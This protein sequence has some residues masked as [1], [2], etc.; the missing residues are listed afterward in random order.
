M[1]SMKKDTFKVE[2]NQKTETWRVI[3]AVDEL[4][5]NHKEIGPRISGVMPQNPTD[6]MCPVRSFT[7]Y[8]DHL[9][10]QNDYLWQIPLRK[11][12]PADPNVWYGLGHIG[13][14]PLAK[15][16]S[17]VSL[18][19]N[20]SQIYTNHCIRVTG[21]SI[22]TRFNFAASEIMSVT[23]LKSIQSLAIYQKT[24]DKTKEEMGSVLC[25]AMNTH[26]ENI[27]KRQRAIQN[28]VQNL[29]LPPPPS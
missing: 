14:N 3:K 24:Q 15:F 7:K 25:Q 6:R 9:N 12:N 21:A 27:Q 28:P 26:D 18:N 1:E 16:M 22:L 13:K 20:L 2:F 19:C 10:P 17:Q 8:Y 5:K 29:V 11:I 23:G 4:S